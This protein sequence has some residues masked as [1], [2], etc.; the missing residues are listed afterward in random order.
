MLSWEAVKSTL[1]IH[2]P[3]RAKGSLIFS[4]DNQRLGEER[5]MVRLDKVYIAKGLF[6]N[7]ANKVAHYTI[8]GDGVKSY[9]HPISCAMELMET[10]TR[11]FCWK[12]N[13]RHFEEAKEQI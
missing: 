8:K 7:Q 4:W 1:D 10:Q 3:L 13:A 12:M 2:E 9:Y 6:Q 11:R 5:I